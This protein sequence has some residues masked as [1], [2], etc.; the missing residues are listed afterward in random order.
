[1]Q[2]EFTE[3][4]REPI[5]IF[6]DRHG[7][8]VI[9]DSELV[10]SG[11]GRKR[12]RKQSCRMHSLGGD[13]AVPQDYFELLSL[14]QES[15]NFPV[16]LARRSLGMRPQHG[17]GI[18]MVASDYRFDFFVSYCHDC[19]LFSQRNTAPDVHSF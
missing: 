18:T 4:G 7:L 3:N 6:D 1:M 19:S 16:A 14:R 9:G 13:R 2:V 11:F 8:A 10:V 15:P 17:K 12:G 5:N